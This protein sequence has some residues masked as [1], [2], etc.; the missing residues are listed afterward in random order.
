M[1]FGMYLVVHL[2]IGHDV[3]RLALV[4]AEQGRKV[5]FIDVFHT[6]THTHTWMRVR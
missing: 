6:Y 4:N 1:C 5:V 2:K 3:S